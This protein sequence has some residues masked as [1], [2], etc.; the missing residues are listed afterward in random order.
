MPRT[1][2]D[3][4]P[5]SAALSA[6][7]RGVERRASLFAHLQ[8]GD[9][10][11][12]D[13]A[14]GA[15]MRAFR[16]QIGDSPMADWPRQFWGQLLATPLLRGGP[17]HAH[18]PEAFDFLGGLGRGPRAA[19]LMRLVADLTD[20]QAA[21]VLGV[22]QPTYRMALQRALP[23]HDDG[24]PDAEAW[25]A[26]LDAA[27]RT[28]RDLPVQRLAHLA[29]LREAA[30]H[31]PAPAPTPAWDGPRR[32]NAAHDGPVRSRWVVPTMIA[33][34][35]LT[36]AALA[37]TFLLP[38]GGR[39]QAQG[40]VRIDVAPLPPATP[41]ARLEGDAALLTHPDFDLLVAADTQPAARDP[42]FYSWLAAGAHAPGDGDAASGSA[43]QA[44]STAAATDDDAPESETSDAP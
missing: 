10:E 6:F 28:L 34:A 24:R 22:A 40:D 20:E 3:T 4:A 30:L 39:D 13:H 16:A 41:P 21:S 8:I 19:L 35:L 31:G 44:A 15:A 27:R 5:A 7:L 25:L 42:A 17:D 11:I 14:L 43:A 37:A 36:A 29:R 2:N 32:G 1:L 23:Y 12:A 33:V 38:F 18:R 9:P 26:L